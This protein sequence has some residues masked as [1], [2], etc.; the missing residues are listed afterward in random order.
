MEERE[1]LKKIGE[2]LSSGAKM[3]SIHCA[4][5]FSPL[6]EQD[7][8]IF[9]PICGEAET[10][11]KVLRNKLK[12]LLQELEKETD[13]EKVMKILEEIRAIKEILK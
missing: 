5:C 13:H 4:E 7:G 8:R 2:I 9:C 1:K 12:K 6:F 10:H 11:E 3:L